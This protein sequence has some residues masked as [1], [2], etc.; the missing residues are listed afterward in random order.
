ME[1]LISSVARIVPVEQQLVLV[2]ASLPRLSDC[3]LMLLL[4]TLFWR[5]K[6]DIP[7][8]HRHLF[9][10]ILRVKSLEQ[11]VRPVL[12]RSVFLAW[13]SRWEM[14]GCIDR[15]LMTLL[16]TVVAAPGAV[17]EDGLTALLDCAIIHSQAP[18]MMR[19]PLIRRMVDYK[20]GSLLP[21]LAPQEEMIDMA[22]HFRHS[23]M[24]YFVKA[25]VSMRVIDLYRIVADYIGI[26]CDFVL[27]L[28]DDTELRCTHYLSFYPYHRAPLVIDVVC[29]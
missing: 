10:E 25:S 2:L 24:F 16:Y 3:S 12:R 5:L 22:L 18:D 11:Q 15:A 20:L 7:P 17:S 23:R 4:R 19:T 26:G 8:L 13:V 28:E 6:Q 9:C 21:V 14:S 27:H 29:Q 1:K